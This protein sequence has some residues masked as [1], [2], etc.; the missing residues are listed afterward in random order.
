MDMSTT[1][2]SCSLMPTMRRRAPA[3]LCRNIAVFGFSN[4]G[5]GV[6]A[7]RSDEDRKLLD[8]AAVRRPDEAGHADQGGPQPST[9]TPAS[10]SAMDVDWYLEVREGSKSSSMREVALSASALSTRGVATAL[11]SRR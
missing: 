7:M 10:A 6:S 9:R 3:C 5:E 4:A 1:I 2:S 11:K 8:G